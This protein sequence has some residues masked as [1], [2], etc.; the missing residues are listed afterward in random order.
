M[1]KRK[2][3][4]RAQV[5]EAP[6]PKMAHP[7]NI[8]CAAPSVAMN[9]SA[10]RDRIQFKIGTIDPALEGPKGICKVKPRGPSILS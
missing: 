8:A 5:T 6:K 10:P 1:E 3:R 9:M 4:T 7:N 2:C